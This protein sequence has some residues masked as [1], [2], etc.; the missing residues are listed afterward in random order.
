M[1]EH[2][3]TVRWNVFGMTDVGRQRKQNEDCILVASS[4]GLF[5]VADGMGGHNA[6]RVASTLAIASLDNFFQATPLKKYETQYLKDHPAVHRLRDA[7]QKANHDVFEISNNYKQH[8]GMGSTVVAFFVEDSNSET[9][10]HIV[11]VGDSRCYRF[12]EGILEQLTKDHSLINEALQLNP[13]LTEAQIAKLPKNIITRALGMKEDVEEEIQSVTIQ[14]GDTYLLCSDGLSGLVKSD[15]I[16]QILELSSNPEEACQ[17]LI[18]MANDAGGIDNISVIV[19]RAEAGPREPMKR[20]IT[21]I[22]SAPVIST[23]KCNQC[24]FDLF[25]GNRFCVECGSK[26]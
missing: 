1:K 4:M 12:R 21:D 24:G 22:L 8:E 6:G 20:K 16:C 25:V 10:V 23:T 11:H 13:D 2:P 19:V 17:L 3:A 15:Q 26:I 9:L 14:I 7:I 5:V 18:D